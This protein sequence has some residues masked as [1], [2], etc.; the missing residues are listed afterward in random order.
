MDVSNVSE[1]VKIKPPNSL[2]H[3]YSFSMLFVNLEGFI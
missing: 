3:F 2:K 1:S